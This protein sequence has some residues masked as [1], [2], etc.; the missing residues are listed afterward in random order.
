MSCGSNPPKEKTIEGIP[1]KISQTIEKYRVELLK[2]TDPYSLRNY[3]E[4]KILLNEKVIFQETNQYWEIHGRQDSL[5]T[6][7]KNQDGSI[8]LYFEFNQRPEPANYLP[9]QLKGRQ[10]K[11]LDFQEKIE[12]K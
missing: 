1:L 10:V 4:I 3:Q 9:I 5:V 8:N 7:I 11:K 2:L 6:K 12:F